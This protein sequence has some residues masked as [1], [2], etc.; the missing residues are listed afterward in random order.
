M[1]TSYFRFNELQ[2]YPGFKM[3]AGER[4]FS[5]TFVVESDILEDVSKWKK[6]DNEISVFK[7]TID[8]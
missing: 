1:S 6:G 3:C 7:L 8:L 4:P 5:Q 2:G